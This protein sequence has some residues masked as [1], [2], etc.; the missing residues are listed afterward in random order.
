MLQSFAVYPNNNC[1]RLVSLSPLKEQ[2]R[3]FV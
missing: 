2:E 1:E 3:D